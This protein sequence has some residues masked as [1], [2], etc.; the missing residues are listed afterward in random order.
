[1]KKRFFGLDVEKLITVE[2]KVEAGQVSVVERVNG[3]KKIRI[4]EYIIP[5]AKVKDYN[6]IYSKLD[7][8]KIS[9]GKPLCVVRTMVMKLIRGHYV[10]TLAG[11]DDFKS[12]GIPNNK[13]FINIELQDTMRRSDGRPLGLGPLC[14][15][16]GIDDIIDHDCVGDAWA[17][18]IIY[19]D[20]LDPITRLPREPFDPDQVIT[21]RE[22]RAKKNLLSSI[23]RK[24]KA[25]RKNRK[26]VKNR[27]ALA[28]C[29]GHWMVT[30]DL[31]IE[32]A[33]LYFVETYLPKWPD[34]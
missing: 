20:Y 30:D 4:D 9:R 6:T 26:V 1:M 7:E 5:S 28:G 32:H 21:T 13:G 14:D 11:G 19:L 25:F 22:Y 24:K 34:E 23:D 10:V 27:P 18:L 12:L 29:E 16:F 15:Y 33:V 2:N 3:E 17:T 31:P 8:E